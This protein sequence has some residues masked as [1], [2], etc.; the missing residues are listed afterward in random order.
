MAVAADVR[1]T[2]SST[3][4]WSPFAPIEAQDGAAL[5]NW[6]AALPSADGG[7][8]LYG[9]SYTGINQISTAAAVGPGSH[10]RRSSR[11]WPGTTCTASW[12]PW[13]GCR[14]PSSCRSGC[15]TPGSAT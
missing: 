4:S 1:G 13:A 5:V 6:A 12:S 10:S 2:G 8:G 14:T 9:D 15:S 11:S 3:G 7:V